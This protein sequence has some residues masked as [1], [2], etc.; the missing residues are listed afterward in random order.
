VK[1]E[2]TPFIAPDWI[3]SRSIHKR[4]FK[5]KLCVSRRAG[6][7]HRLGSLFKPCLPKVVIA[8]NNIGLVSISGSLDKI[9]S[10]TLHVH[11]KSKETTEVWETIAELG[12][13]QD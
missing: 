2:A 5:N 10:H 12:G 4:C 13:Y 7:I 9:L 1:G 6:L 11:K 3:E 8:E